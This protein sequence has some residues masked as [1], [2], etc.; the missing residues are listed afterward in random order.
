MEAT[1][2]AKKIDNLKSFEI[3][4]SKL[5]NIFY[6]ILSNIYNVFKVI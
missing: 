3:F 2:S 4:H 6:I 5:N 1:L